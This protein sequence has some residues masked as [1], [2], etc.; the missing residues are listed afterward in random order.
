MALT[1]AITLTVCTD[2]NVDALG[3]TAIVALTEAS[4]LTVCT[5]Q[6]VDTLG[7]H[8]SA[9]ETFSGRHLSF[10]NC[11]IFVCLDGLPV[12]MCIN[13]MPTMLLA[14]NIGYWDQRHS[15][16]PCGYCGYNPGYYSVLTKGS[17]RP[18]WNPGTNLPLGRLTQKDHL[19]LPGAGCQGRNEKFLFIGYKVSVLQG[20]EVGQT[21]GRDGHT[22][23]WIYL[24][25]LKRHYGG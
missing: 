6:N 15:K 2:Q 24:L 8:Y 4:T 14:A 16:V 3:D 11:I 18:L 12:S 10:S 19:M 21:N 25:P 20:E 17:G 13:H 9:Y 7:D 23:I 5:H 1:E 22:K